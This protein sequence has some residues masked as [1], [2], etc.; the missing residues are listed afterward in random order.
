MTEVTL[1]KINSIQRCVARAREEHRLAEGRFAEN[2]SRQDAAILN[3][4]RGCETALDLANYVIRKGKL[5]IPET[6]R[7]SFALLAQAHLLPK[8]LSD[9][10]ERMIAFRN[11]AVHQYANLEIAKVE[12]IILHNLDDLVLFTETIAG[13][14]D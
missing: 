3:I 12:Q 2:Q 10:L 6:S 8:D 9:R 13:T 5:G 7:E 11:L 14:L 1:S 4:L